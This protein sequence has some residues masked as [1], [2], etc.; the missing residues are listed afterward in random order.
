MRLLTVIG[1]VV[2]LLGILSFVVPVPMN[3]TRSAKVGD[4]SIAIT[5]Q[6]SQKLPPVVGGVLRRRRRP[7]DLWHAPRHRVRPP[8][9][10]VPKQYELDNSSPTRKRWDLTVENIPSPFEGRDKEECRRLKPAPGFNK[11]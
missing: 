9:G 1:V 8:D 11:I 4:A 7:A 2:L 10:W 6:E 3:H 5:T